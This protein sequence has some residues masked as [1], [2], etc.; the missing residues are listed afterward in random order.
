MMALLQYKR[1]MNC[2]IL[3]IEMF[4]CGARAACIA[5]VRTTFQPVKDNLLLNVFF[6]E[7]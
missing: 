3:T 5:G 6:L 4:V 2:S 7:L 1:N